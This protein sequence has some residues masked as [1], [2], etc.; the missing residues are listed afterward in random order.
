[1]AFR[2]EDLKLRLN[3]KLVSKLPQLR[4]ELSVVEIKRSEIERRKE[5]MEKLLVDSLPD[6]VVTP[7]GVTF[8]P[9]IDGKSWADWQYE[10]EVKEK[11]SMRDFVLKNDP[12][13]RFWARLRWAIVLPASGI[14]GAGS[15][16]VAD[17]IDR[18]YKLAQTAGGTLVAVSLSAVAITIAILATVA[19]KMLENLVDKTITKVQVAIKDS[20]AAEFLKKIDTITEKKEEKPKIKPAKRFEAQQQ[21]MYR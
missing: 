19:S 15:N 5:E 16:Y 21:S 20:E 12:K 3:P 2:Q 9:I 14:I 11:E 8:G 6:I 1:M 10:F 4:A 13:T 18:T 17:F 7:G